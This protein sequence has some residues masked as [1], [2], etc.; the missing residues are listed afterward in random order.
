MRGKLFIVVDMDG[1][2]V[3]LRDAFCETFLEFET[4][5]LALEIEIHWAQ[6]VYGADI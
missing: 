6:W 5:Q 3:G 1:F 4:L 2:N